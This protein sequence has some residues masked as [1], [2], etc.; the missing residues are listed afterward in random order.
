[1]LAPKMGLCSRFGNED[2]RGG[3]SVKGPERALRQRDPSGPS[4]MPDVFNPPSVIPDVFN[5]PSVIPD[6]FNRESMFFPCRATRR[7]G[8]KRKT[9][10]SR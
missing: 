6:V 2:Y 9:L 3:D 1:M 5:S 8:Q 7:K 10:D 4:V